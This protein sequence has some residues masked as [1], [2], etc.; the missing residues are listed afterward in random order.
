ME[1]NWGHNCLTS[2]VHHGRP[3]AL[4]RLPLLQAV[5]IFGADELREMVIA[6]IYNDAMKYV[7]HCREMN[8]SQ[9]WADKVKKHAEEMYHRT[10]QHKVGEIAN[11]YRSPE[12]KSDQKNVVEWIKENKLNPNYA[13]LHPHDSITL[14]CRIIGTSCSMK[15]TKEVYN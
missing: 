9:Q 14:L 15:A 1:I 4:W 12:W 8:F 10:L 13:P 7:I 6:R 2:G 3:G 5:Q 11:Y